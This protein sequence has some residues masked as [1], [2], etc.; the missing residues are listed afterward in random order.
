MTETSKRLVAKGTQGYLVIDLDLQSTPDRISEVLSKVVSTKSPVALFLHDYWGRVEFDKL[1]EWIPDR[2]LR[3]S[4]QSFIGSIR[5]ESHRVRHTLELDAN[6]VVNQALTEAGI[7]L[8]P[9]HPLQKVLKQWATIQVGGS[10]VFLPGVPFQALEMLD[11]ATDSQIQR[12]KRWEIETGSKEVRE[13]FDEWQGRALAALKGREVVLG[14][15]GWGVLGSYATTL[16]FVKTVLTTLGGVALPAELSDFMTLPNL[17]GIL[18]GSALSLLFLRRGKEGGWTEFEEYSGEIPKAAKYWSTVLTDEEKLAISSELDCVASLPPGSSYGILEARF[19]DPDS[20]DVEAIAEALAP[21]FDSVSEDCRRSIE[22]ELEKVHTALIIVLRE[23]EVRVDRIEAEV[24]SMKREV[25]DSFQIVK[26]EIEGPLVK[27][28][29][30]RQPARMLDLVALN[31]NLLPLISARQASIVTSSRLSEKIDLAVKELINDRKVIIIGEEGV[32]K[33][34]LL[35]LVCRRLITTGTPVFFGGVDDL[36]SDAVYVQDNLTPSSEEYEAKLRLS[37]PIVATVRMTDWRSSEAKGWTEISLEPSDFGPEICKRILTR[38]LRT[39]AVRWSE[40]GLQA[41]IRKSQRLPIYLVELARWLRLS[42]RQLDESTVK[43]APNDVR[44][45]ILDELTLPTVPP[46]ERRMIVQLLYCMAL[47]SRHRLHRAHLQSLIQSLGLA[48]GRW[49]PEDIP[50][51]F[52]GLVDQFPSSV[53]S[54]SHDLWA[55]VLLGFR[56]AGGEE[57]PE[58]GGNQKLRDFL[59]EA[60]DKSVAR[61]FELRPDEAENVM[62]VS[63]ENQRFLSVRFL[64]EAEHQDQHPDTAMLVSEVVAHGDPLAVGEYLAARIDPERTSLQDQ[65]ILLERIAE[66]RGERAPA[67]SSLV[68]RKAEGVA[69]ELV[70]PGEERFRPDLAKVLN[71]LGD[72]FQTQGEHGEAIDCYQE[73]EEIYR[74]LAGSGEAQIRSDLARVLNNLGRALADQGSLSDAIACC[75]ESEGIYRELLVGGEELAHPDLA[76]V[77]N[78][79]GNILSEQGKLD[80]AI[81]RYRECETIR[82]DLVGR[83]EKRYRPELATVL[84][85][86][87]AVLRAQGKLDGAVSSYRECEKMRRELLSEGEERYR[88]DL[89]AV[90][91]D[92]GDVLSDQDKLDEATDCC[93]ESEGI[94]RQLVGRGEERYRPDLAKVLN[95]LGSAL[96]GQGKL[97]EAVA[98]YQECERMRRELVGRGEER[99]LPDLAMVLN[100]LGASLLA[101]GKLDDT[102]ASYR[103]CEEVYRGL[104]NKGDERFL[105]D[106]AMVLNN[107]GVTFRYRGRLDEAIASYRDCERIRRELV[108]RGEDQFIPDLAKVLINLSV[109]L[110]YQ[111]KVEEANACSKEVEHLVGGARHDD[112]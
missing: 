41:A 9:A 12:I 106:L 10:G 93:R 102:I 28:L 55:E 71:D 75:K 67:F 57:F 56:S 73:C 21:Q 1:Q 60:F 79:L 40:E 15:A 52:Y 2:P 69:R 6:Q 32:G 36:P 112:E 96:S 81:A 50:A 94:Y 26:D 16:D 92:I 7:N 108:R 66:G 83:G 11:A 19:H 62:R 97:D 3:K 53:F 5:S 89:A 76:K 103:E 38:A 63:I 77:L 44:K 105:P 100:N 91:N 87:G 23:L 42:H 99:Y 104:I 109:A 22:K 51:A 35:Y 86:L 24:S 74:D 31:T 95:N 20:L 8:E 110:K 101:Q 43:E 111:G 13:L 65:L 48:V 17:G 68:L 64:E 78:N 70:S 18:L 30:P 14:V 72:T 39:E 85:C 82:R 61:V 98:R 59:C 49:L 25:R 46:A 34:I 37:R 58:I 45:L 4:I 80:E 29:K 54:F 90:L 88:P 33:S 27:I 47:T 107:L 84:G